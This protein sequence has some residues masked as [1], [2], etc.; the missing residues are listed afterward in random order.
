LIVDDSYFNVIALKYLLKGLNIKIDNA[1]DG[2][3]A[4]EKFQAN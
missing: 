1:N 4:L 2:L 3:E